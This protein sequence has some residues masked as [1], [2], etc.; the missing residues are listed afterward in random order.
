MYC[1]KNNR[2]TSILFDN[3]RKQIGGKRGGGGEGGGERGGGGRGGEIG[4][5]ERG[6]GEQLTLLSF[7]WGIRASGLRSAW[8]IYT[9]YL[10]LQ[11]R[12]SS[13]APPSLSLF[14]FLPFPFLCCVRKPETELSLFL[15]PLPGKEFSFRLSEKRWRNLKTREKKRSFEPDGP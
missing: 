14:P 1:C 7:L 5:G 13:S 12:L 9:K 15:A 4:G 6:G 11:V 3:E 8:K 10:P 2:S